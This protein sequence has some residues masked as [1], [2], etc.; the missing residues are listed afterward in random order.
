MNNR[1]GNAVFFTL[2]E[3]WD[4]CLDKIYNKPKYIQGFIDALKQYGIT[5]ES[6]ILDAGCG[7]GF[8]PLDLIERGYHVVAADKSSEMV[9]QIGLNAKKRGL[10]VQAI[11]ATWSEL[12]RFVGQGEFDLVYCR[13]NSLVYAAS[14]EQ[15]W[16]VPARSMEEI[17]T[18]LR[19]F[20]SV[21]KPGG[22]LYLDVTNKKEKPHVENIG[23]IA[24]RHGDARL[25]WQIEHN[26]VTKVRTWT[27][28]LIFLE[29]GDV[30]TYPSYSYLLSHEELIEC[31][32]KIG[33]SK[34]R[35]EVK[36]KGENNYDVFIARK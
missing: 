25:T 34:V 2:P 6:K 28:R 20:H 31:L 7:S 1:R 18:A 17:Q 10:E 36:V 21:L 35:L 26:V 8:P 12:Q 11:H 9:R 29:T 33:F 13:G 16:I 30:K 22:V 19:N 24:T 27:M 4:L 15:N 32:T 3:I 14:W 5:S 23:T